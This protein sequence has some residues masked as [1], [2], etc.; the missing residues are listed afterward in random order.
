M[1]MYLVAT[2]SILV[3]GLG[4]WSA[5]ARL[6]QLGFPGLD[7]TARVIMLVAAIFLAGASYVFATAPG[8]GPIVAQFFTL[9]LGQC[10]GYLFVREA[11]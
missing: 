9:C 11:V 6:Q 1:N 10:V 5:S 7:T 4:Y 2:V 3:F 8:V